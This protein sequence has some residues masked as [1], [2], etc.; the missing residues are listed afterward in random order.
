MCDN[1]LDKEIDGV[2][3]WGGGKGHR[4][5]DLIFVRFNRYDAVDSISMIF[6]LFFVLN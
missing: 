3:G 5:R 4:N 6:H 1:L 2:L